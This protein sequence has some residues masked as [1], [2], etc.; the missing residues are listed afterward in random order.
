MNDEDVTRPS[1]KGCNHR[2]MD[3][4]TL[5]EAKG[6]RRWCMSCGASWHDRHDVIVND[7]SPSAV[8]DP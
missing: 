2:G 5:I 4:D 8:F 6:D 7:E 3:G 1:S